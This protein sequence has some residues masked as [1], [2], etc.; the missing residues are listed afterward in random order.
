MSC[1]IIDSMK[2]INE[3]KEEFKCNFN[4]W[5]A[6]ADKIKELKDKM[7]RIEKEREEYIKE[8]DK[9]RRFYYDEKSENR[10]LNNLLN[11]K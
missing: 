1:K 9:F 5:L 11:N 8:N 6:Q 10:R 3:I 7:R 4:G 2:D